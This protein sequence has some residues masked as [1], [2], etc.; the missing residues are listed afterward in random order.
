MSTYQEATVKRSLVGGWL[1][2]QNYRRPY[3]SANHRKYKNISSKRAN[4]GTALLSCA[5]DVVLL[6]EIVTVQ[7][8]LRLV[9]LPTVPTTSI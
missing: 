6:P 3:E 8:Q 2:P 5:Q 4:I 9:Y 7:V 1:F